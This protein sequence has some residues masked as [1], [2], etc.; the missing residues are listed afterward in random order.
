MLWPLA[1][2]QNFELRQFR[3]QWNNVNSLEDFHILVGHV[4]KML[5]SLGCL[6][7]ING[8]VMFFVKTVLL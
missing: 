5:L 3:A 7:N 8:L 4:P 1:S 2:E 6:R